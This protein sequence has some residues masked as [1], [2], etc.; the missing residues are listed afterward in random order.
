MRVGLP[1]RS[2]I[3]PSAGSHHFLSLPFKR[4]D[5]RELTGIFLCFEPTIVP[6]MCL[7]ELHS[8]H[9]KVPIKGG[10]EATVIY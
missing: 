7:N 9:R 6:Q 4:F 10:L 5:N 2:M 1:I 8:N 3:S